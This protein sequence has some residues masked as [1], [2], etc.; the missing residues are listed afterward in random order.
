MSKRNFVL[1]LILSTLFAIDFLKIS[2]FPDE[3]VKKINES[4]DVKSDDISSLSPEELKLDDEKIENNNEIGKINKNNK[5]LRNENNVELHFLVCKS[6][7]SNV[8][9]IKKNL[10]GKFS[11]IDI[12]IKFDEPEY[13]KTMISNLL[14]GLKILFIAIS[15]GGEAIK[16]YVITF[17][18]ENIFNFILE[19]KMMFS[20]ISWFG[21]S[22]ISTYITNT[23]TFS[24][25]ADSQFT[26]LIFSS[27]GKIP[28]LDSLINSIIDS[29]IELIE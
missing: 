5:S 1:L 20:M 10:L 4:T 13:Y 3:V 12:F 27:K 26:E 29:G 25:Y 22:Y 24:L 14:F 11:N 28:S 19:K 23:N 7:T 16:P 2:F 6:F 15:L 8:E 17:I 9:E 18:P 21:F